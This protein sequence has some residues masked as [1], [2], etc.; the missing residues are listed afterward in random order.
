M[1]LINTLR[2]KMGKFIVAAVA[3]AIMSFVMA[4]L[5]GPNSTLLGGGND[6]GEIAGKT[7]TLKE[8]QNAVQ[9]RESNFIL[10]FNR[11]PTEQDRPTL[12]QQA[13]DLLITKYAFEEQYAEVG[14]QVTDDE[15]W[16]ML[17]GKNINPG[18][19]QA[20]T[21]PETGQ[22][23]RD[24]FMNYLQQLP[25][26]APEA[27]VRWELFKND[28][29]P[30]RKRIKYENLL[31]KSNLVTTAEAKR[32][33]N[34]QNDVA[35]I[36][37]LYVPYYAVSDSA[38]KIEESALKAYYNK[39]KE[40]YKVDHTKS[41][42]YVSFQVIPSTD[43]STFVRE[44]LQTLK[45]E[46]GK[47]Q[48]DSVFASLN[49]DGLTYF[50]KYHPGTL[51]L[52][53]K[54]NISNL[55]KGDV[56]G[57]YLDTEGFKLYKVTDIFEDTVAF[58]KASHILIKG[59]DDDAKTKARD[60]LKQIKNGADFAEMAREHGTDGTST[61]G[62]DLGWFESGKMVAE[63]ETAVFKA[64]KVGL[65]DDVVKT[66]FGYHIIKVDELKNNTAY[67][68]ATVERDVLPSDETINEAFTKADMFAASVDD[69]KSFDAQ[70]KADS[71][72]AVPVA[73]L[74]AN[75]RRVGALGDARQIV[76]WL[77]TDAS[78]GDISRVFE[79]D[80]D[81]VVAVM[82]SE[83]EE[84]YQPLE[85]VVAEVTVK[86]KNETKGAQI[87]EKLTG[88]TGSLEDRAAA[89]GTDANIYTSS[90]LLLS[91]TSIPTVGFDPLAVGT[92]F[93]LE[94]G[95][96]SKPFAGENGV[97]IVMMENKT[98]APEIADYTTYKN[99][100]LQKING[101]VGYNITEA[102]KENADIKD[103]RYKVY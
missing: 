81:Y 57:P 96:T 8:F 7:I 63:F 85:F 77:F 89:Y 9:E 20:F 69:L 24:Q 13:W 87:I 94:A 30:G 80:N 4:D 33:Y 18:L 88:L 102:I 78:T 17:Q 82:T 93:S 73:K 49:T 72:V 83:I 23:D 40:K 25:S 41:L 68:I 10:N 42:K 3:I 99:Q 32:E 86:V 12:R 26:L 31:A 75:D 67:K 48:D 29:V 27:Q 52:Q 92:A 95:E 84:G 43:D 60:I 55:S 16:D 1:A 50:G 59:D 15:V 98:I 38:V 65:L 100:V 64:R 97:L 47:V 35:E 51:P 5:F 39:N 79:L 103:E 28:L 54:A 34:I 62:G 101:Q 37:Y 19:L 90:N 14:V 66:Q 44:E 58:A 6:V 91:A 45:Q 56:R 74:K 76:Q 11:Q 36:K 46:F 70:V 21:N 61:R 53:L 71:M 2:N 22:Y